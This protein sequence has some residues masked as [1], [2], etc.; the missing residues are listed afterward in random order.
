MAF[1]FRTCQYSIEIYDSMLHST[2][3]PGI[4]LVTCVYV[5]CSPRSIHFHEWMEVDFID[6]IIEDKFH[7]IHFLSLQS[8]HLYIAWIGTIIADI[9]LFMY[10]FL[11]FLYKKSLERCAQARKNMA[12]KWNRVNRR[13][14]GEGG[15]MSNNS[16]NK[17]LH[18]RNNKRELRLIDAS[19]VRS[20]IG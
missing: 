14:G 6:V 18:K 4:R 10:M 7:S 13:E 8:S 11:L 19:C 16:S 9:T 15:K 3:F 12:T 2:T 17:K 5:A 1:S 20:D